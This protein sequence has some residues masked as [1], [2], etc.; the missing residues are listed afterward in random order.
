[1]KFLVQIAFAVILTSC[2]LTPPVGQPVSKN[3]LRKDLSEQVRGTGGTSTTEMPINAGRPIFIE[4]WSYPQIVDT[5]DIWG[6]GK[7]YINVGRE[8][9]TLN[10]VLAKP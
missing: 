9:I 7:I 1:M 4:A 8:E 3:A 5:G 2:S 6:G 10:D